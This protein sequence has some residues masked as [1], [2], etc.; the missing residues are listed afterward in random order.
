MFTVYALYSPQYQ[1]IYIGYT[2]NLEERIKSHNELG[3]KGWT[4]RYRPW[5]LVHTETFGSKGEAMAREKQLKSARGRETIWEI[6]R[7]KKE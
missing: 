7:Q 5:T 6:I 1:K 2:S 4:V 3:K